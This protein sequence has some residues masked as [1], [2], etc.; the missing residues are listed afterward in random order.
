MSRLTLFAAAL[1]VAAPLSAQDLSV[2]G[3]ADAG[4]MVPYDAA[5]RTVSNEALQS[6]LY[7]LISLKHADHQAH[8]NVVGPQFYSLHDLLG[9]LY[10]ALD[11]YIDQIAERQRALGMA[12]DGDPGRAA[13]GDGLDAFPEGLLADY[14]VPKILSERYMT[15]IERIEMR[16]TETGDAGD[17]VTQDL[18]I[19]T[20][21]ELEK[22][23]WMLRSFQRQADGQ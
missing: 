2:Y 8:W 23:L 13:S 12:A 16:V 22:H 7:E 21:H 4:Q 19:G 3:S 18:L 15:V 20:A 1:L 5:T 6:T 10:G 17:S 14:N 11:P 9:D